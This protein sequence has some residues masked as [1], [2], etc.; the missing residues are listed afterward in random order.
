MVRLRKD[1]EVGEARKA[2]QEQSPEV[3]AALV[4]ESKGCRTISGVVVAC[5]DGLF[6]RLGTQRHEGCAGIPAEGVVI[7]ET[8]Y[9]IVAVV[10][11]GCRAG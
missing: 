6:Q 7:G 5:Q 10:I 9:V 8:S 1:I 4:L 3:V 11:H 2:E